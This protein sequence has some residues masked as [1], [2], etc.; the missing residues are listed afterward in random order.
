MGAAPAD[1][2]V[3][4]GLDVGTTAAKVSAFAL[5]GDWR[6][7]VGNE[8]PLQ[9]PQP[10]WE[11]QEPEVMWRALREGLAEIA[12]EVGAASVVGVGVSTALHGLIGLD[13]EYRPL[14]P[15]LTWADSRA[16]EQAMRLRDTELGRRLHRTSG[17]PVH[18]M[19]HLTKLLWFAE[20]DPETASAVRWWVGLKDYILWQLTGEL[21]TEVSHASGTG[22]LD[23]STRDWNEEALQVTGVRREQLPPVRPTTEAFPLLPALAAAVGLP[24]GTRVVLGAGDGP[25]G[26]LGV[27][28][29]E[30][31]VVGLSLGTSGA[32]RMVTDRPYVDEAG[33]LFCYNLANDAWVIG[34]AISNGGIVV[35]WG[36]DVFGADF[37]DEPGG[38]PDGMLLDLARDVPIGAEGLI[39]LPFLMA[40]RAPLW[41]P[42]IPGAFLGVRRS[43]TREYFVRAAVEGVALMLSTI[44]DELDRV[45]PVRQIR[46]TGG[47]FRSTVWREV[48]AA[49]LGK[50]LVVTDG[51]DGTA[52]GAA[53]LAL[54]GLGEAASLRDA[55]IALGADPDA[56]SDELIPDPDD[57][58]AYRA[59]RAGIPALLARYDEVR[60]LFS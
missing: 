30:P 33:K 17:T 36:G 4:I 38:N 26:N 60:N 56:G 50:P 3:V 19:S 21:V 2:R 15:L 44:V 42:T 48:L 18:S 11:V 25:L 7:S 35:R 14:T 6:V 57:V 10:G 16:A 1:A 32:V 58:A 8:Y 20:H 51:A 41:N 9:Q 12:G 49:A 47:V 13:A 29:L 5:G 46:A 27:G 22:L 43:H 39:A 24:E 34:G 52:L 37:A 54:Y 23:L 40:E 53:A 59:V 31:G 55:L 28:A 45:S